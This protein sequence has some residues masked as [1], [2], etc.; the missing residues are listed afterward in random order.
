[1]GF[2]PVFGIGCFEIA[3]KRFDCRD[4][5]PGIII[6]Q[7]ALVLIDGNASIY[8]SDQ[9]LIALGRSRIII[10]STQES[11]VPGVGVA[12]QYL[13]RPGQ[14]HHLPFRSFS[15]RQVMDCVILL[16]GGREVVSGQV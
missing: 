5:G 4:V 11:L 13:C 14:V 15:A 16:D 3:I 7:A 2:S 6:H 10:Y 1:M 12:A 8:Q 9:R